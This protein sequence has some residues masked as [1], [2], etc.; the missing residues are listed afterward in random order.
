MLKFMKSSRSIKLIILLVTLSMVLTACG[1]GKSAGEGDKLEVMLYSSLKDTQLAAIK[2]KFMAKHE[3]VNMD[4]YTAGT[5]SVMTKLA[6]EQQ[7]GGI[8]ADMIWVGD[9][10][11]YIK[12]KADDLLLAYDLEVPFL[13]S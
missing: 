11:N 13:T 7:A 6:T 2:E 3:N 8:S 12:F 9:P 10:T 4:Y 1:G 5:G